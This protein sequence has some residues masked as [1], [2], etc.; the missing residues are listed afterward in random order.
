MHE[1]LQVDIGRLTYLSHLLQGCLSGKY[2]SL[3][4]CLLQKLYLFY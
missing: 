2:D 1:T 4:A 3:K